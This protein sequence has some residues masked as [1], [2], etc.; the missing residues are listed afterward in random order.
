ME[1]PM[2]CINICPWCEMVLAL[3]M[4]YW[5]Q[6]TIYCPACGYLLTSVSP[7]ERATYPQDVTV[8]SPLCG[9]A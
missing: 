8:W 9:V 6:Q 2:L 1:C 5:E 7:D 3:P 4:E